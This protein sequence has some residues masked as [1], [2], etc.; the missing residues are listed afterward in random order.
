MRNER[1]DKVIYD[2]RQN[3]YNLRQIIFI[4]SNIYIAFNQASKRK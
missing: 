2:I 1:V 3:N 4:S